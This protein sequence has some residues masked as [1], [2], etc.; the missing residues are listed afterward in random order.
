MQTEKEDDSLH[1]SFNVELPFDI[2]SDVEEENIADDSVYDDDEDVPAGPVTYTV[3]D[4]ATQRGKP[5]LVDNIGFSYTLKSEKNGARTWQCSVRNK[6]IH[7]GVIVHEKDGVFIPPSIQHNHTA[8]P[9]TL[10]ATKIKVTTPVHS[11]NVRS[12]RD[13]KDTNKMSNNVNT[14]D[15]MIISLDK[16]T[17]RSKEHSI[18]NSGEV[19]TTGKSKEHSILNAAENDFEYGL[20]KVRGFYSRAQYVIAESTLRKLRHKNFDTSG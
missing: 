4:N 14:A 13:R 6:T 19:K 17:D 12:G 8:A 2:P 20:Q 3:I 16:I 9:G 7:C 10:T 15:S 18:S 11:E 1:A 5:K